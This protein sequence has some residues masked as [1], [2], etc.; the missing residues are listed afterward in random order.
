MTVF[1]AH[2]TIFRQSQRRFLERVN[3]SITSSTSFKQRF[4]LIIHDFDVA[5]CLDLKRPRRNRSIEPDISID[6]QFVIS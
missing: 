4:Y 2:L 3:D 6:H 1:K 5:R